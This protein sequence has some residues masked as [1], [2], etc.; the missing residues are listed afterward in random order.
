MD[1]KIRCQSCGMPLGEF[2]VQGKKEDN[3]GTDHDHS[4]TKEFCKFC[5]QN[6]E[7]TDPNLTLQGMIDRSVHFMAKNLK[8][9]TQEATELSE[10]VIP[11]L[12]RWKK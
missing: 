9:T 7:F 3:F 11:K 6:G 2:E 1:D 8:F 10:S 12:K 5:F 4:K